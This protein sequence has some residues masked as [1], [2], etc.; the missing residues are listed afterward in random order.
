MGVN[1][2]ARQ[3]RKPSG[4]RY[5]SRRSKRVFEQGRLPSASTVSENN[6][7]TMLRTRGA[8]SKARVTRVHT[9]NLFDTTEKKHVKATV[10]KVLENAA[11]RHFV[12]QNIITQGAV[13]ETDKGKARVTS[14][15]GQDG[16]VNAIL[17]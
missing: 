17:L 1:H 8:N 3:G 15:P 4:G 10:N 9:V 11:N 2:R 16:T 14:R 7:V 6:K 5:I 13:I 12:R